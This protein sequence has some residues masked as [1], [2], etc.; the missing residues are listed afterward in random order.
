MI[1][2]NYF[3]IC[4][5]FPRE[6]CYM[7]SARTEMWNC[8]K[9]NLLKRK[10]VISLELYIN[11]WLNWRNFVLLSWKLTWNFIFFRENC[12]TVPEQKCETVEKEVT[13]Q[14]CSDVVKPPVCETILG[15]NCYFVTKNTCSKDSEPLPGSV[16]SIVEVELKFTFSKKA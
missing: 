6:N 12:Y 8:S 15:E 3:T 4:I 14:K 11:L 13:T 2:Y 16:T 5:I 10:Y 1:T 7:Y 9:H